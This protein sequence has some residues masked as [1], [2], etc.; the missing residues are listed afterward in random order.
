SVFAI[1]GGLKLAVL[2]TS[3]VLFLII[4]FF[5]SRKC[6]KV[7]RFF[8]FCV[9]VLGSTAPIAP[10]EVEILSLFSLKSERL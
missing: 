5:L 4:C 7:L 1:F 3:Q 10:M 2:W 9:V 6:A 8:L